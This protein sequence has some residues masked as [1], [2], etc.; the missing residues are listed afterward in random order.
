MSGGF[1][2]GT[3][4]IYYYAGLWTGIDHRTLTSRHFDSYVRALRWLGV[5][6]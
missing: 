6:R 5:A 3:R 2:N 1:R 4:H